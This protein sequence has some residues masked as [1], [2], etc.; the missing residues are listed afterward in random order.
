MGVGPGDAVGVYMPMVPQAVIAAYAVARIGAIYLPIFSG[1]GAPAIKTRLDDAGA[2][3]L[4]VADGFYRRGSK[5]P[6]KA[7][8]GRG[9]DRLAERREGVRLPALPG[10]RHAVGALDVTWDDAFRLAARDA[11][12]LRRSIPRPRS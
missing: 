11:S 7:D 4:F 3:A 2:K 6:M 10:R 12:R 1:F 9:G 8:R 5:V